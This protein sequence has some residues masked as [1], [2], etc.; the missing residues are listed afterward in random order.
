MLIVNDFDAV[1]AVIE[2]RDRLAAELAL[3]RE[4]LLQWETDRELLYDDKEVLRAENKWLRKALAPI[5][6]RI[7]RFDC[8]DAP[9]QDVFLRSSE[10]A[11]LDAALS[12]VSTIP[13]ACAGTKQAD[14][15]VP[16]TVHDFPVP[17]EDCAQIGDKPEAVND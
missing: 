12:P 6:A 14:S 1:K 9:T 16:Q 13:R 17:S 5:M 8:G 3:E 11:A 10:I 2:V 4:K 7:D 15:A